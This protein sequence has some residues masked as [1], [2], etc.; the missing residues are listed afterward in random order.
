MSLL[1]TKVYSSHTLLVLR[2]LTL[3][4]HLKTCIF[5]VTKVIYKVKNT[6]DEPQYHVAFMSSMCDDCYNNIDQNERDYSFLRLESCDCSD[7]SDIQYETL[8]FSVM[9]NMNDNFI[10]DLGMNYSQR[11]HLVEP[12]AFVVHVSPFD[13]GDDSTNW[14]VDSGSTYHMNGF[15][16]EFFNMKLEGYDDGLLVKGLVSGTKTYGIGS[17]IV[18]VKDSVEMNHRICLEDVLYVPILLHHHPRIFSVI[19]ACS[20]DECQ[21]HFQSKSYVLKIKLAKIDLNLCS[22]LLWI[23]TIDPSI[24]P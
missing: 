10:D 22:S 6:E 2:F 18:V 5:R 11:T 8:D 24:V 1:T 13:N 12:T 14:I 16:N 4:L 19:S 20:Q 23:P 21:C 7:D 9:S 3:F 15:A 17:C